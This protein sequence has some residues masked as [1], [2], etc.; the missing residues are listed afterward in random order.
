MRALVT[1]GSGFLGGYIVARLLADGWETRTFCRR[2][3]AELARLGVDQR[4]GDLRSYDDV[5]RACQDCDVVF[6][7][8]AFPSIVMNPKPYY[9]TNVLGTRN[10]IAGCL[11]Q[12]VRKLVYTSTQCVANTP[13]SQEGV[14]ESIPI[15]SKFLGWYQMTKAFAERLTRAANY[16]P[17]TDDYD[18]GGVDLSEKR[19]R[20]LDASF[21]AKIES[22]DPD[23]EDALMTVALRPHLIWGPGDRN[24]VP[25][26]VER[27]RSG[28][29]R[30]VGDGSNLISTIYVQNAADAHVLA[31]GAL[32]PRGVVPGS[33]YYIAQE[34]PVNC[35][36]WIDEILA[37]VDEPPVAKSVSFK[38]AWR[39]GAALENIYRLFGKQ[40]EPI[41]T[42]FLAIQLANSY[43]FNTSRAKRDLG[44]APRVSTEEGMR[45]MGEDLKNRGV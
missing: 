32:E 17:W 18:F 21:N 28:R 22:R 27:A 1:G 16:A 38:T 19:F 41:M 6:H 4:L 11:K 5:A 40:G 20:S 37:L 15:A 12:K 45:R 42:R 23:R 8:A 2:K 29:L 3:N 26:L 14:D 24:L 39:V 43:W 44:F 10:V 30:R 31:A 36:Q 34:K 9:E 35:W 13:R 25:R 7:T 33:V